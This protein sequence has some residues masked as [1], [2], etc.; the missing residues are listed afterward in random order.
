MNEKENMPMDKKTRVMAAL[1]EDSVDRVPMSFWRHFAGEDAQGQCCVEN[2]VDFYYQ[3]QMDFIKVMHDGLIA[4]CSLD[5]N[6]VSDLRKYRQQGKNNPY[7]I[8]YLERAKGITDKIGDQVY[9]YANVFAPFTLLRR[10][11]DDKLQSYIQQDKS[12]VLY[13]LNVL[14]EE[15]ALLCE[16][17]VKEANCL[18]L[19]TAFQG[20]EINRFTPE[21]FMEIVYPS[22][23]LML[24]AANDVSAWNILHFC[25]WDEIKNQLHLWKDYKGCVVNWAIYVEELSLVKG[26]DYFGNRSVLG[27]FDN[28]RGRTLYQGN[29][30]EVIAETKK[31]VSDYVIAKGSTQGLILGADC[32]FLTDFELTR[33]NWVAQALREIN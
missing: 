32:S 33:F 22:D 16:L 8:K 3:T 19:F 9:V 31:I 13:A 23:Q 27:G 7:I 24:N 28:R 10:I 4:P 15:L 26:L 30:Q 6:H 17:L 2:H 29:Q 1:N 14:A 12:S 21:E 11:G 18:G 5:V 20:A 25:G